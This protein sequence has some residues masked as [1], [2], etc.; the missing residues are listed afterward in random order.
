[1]TTELQAID[2][3]LC[4]ERG[5]H[6]AELAQELL[7]MLVAELPNYSK[8]IKTA[9]AQQD[10]GL[11]SLHLNKLHG[12]CCY[13]GVPQL[14]QLVETAITNIDQQDK[15]PEATCITSILNQIKL[16]I[17]DAEKIKAEVV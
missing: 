2:W 15:L 9:Y 4:L 3:S 1:M 16:T 17:E 10:S 6:Q 13:S 8:Q 14:Q 11:L 5:N 7:N 12:A